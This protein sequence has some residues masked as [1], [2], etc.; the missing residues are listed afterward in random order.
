MGTQVQVT[1]RVV[2]DTNVVISALLFREGRLAWLRTHWNDHACVPL[3]SR[4]SV[5]EITRVLHYPKFKLLQNDVHELLADYLPYC[6][7]VHAEDRC[8]IV[9][10]DVHDQHFLAL[11]QSG[12]ADVL[13][14]GDNDLLALAGTTAFLIESPEI[15][16]GRFLR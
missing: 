9:C 15:Y 2:F 8:P 10:R 5:R 4:S 7:L 3:V 13:V 14:T 6:E 12:K 16:S 11:A 1:L